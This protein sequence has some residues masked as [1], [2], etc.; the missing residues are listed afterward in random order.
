MCYSALNKTEIYE[1]VNRG[2]RK[3][4]QKVECQLINVER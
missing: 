4:S 1:K 3:L 2:K